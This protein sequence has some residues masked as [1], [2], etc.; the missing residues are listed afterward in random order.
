MREYK[1][2]FNVKRDA[3]FTKKQCEFCGGTENC[4][5]GV[6]FGDNSTESICLSC[7]DNKKASVDVPVYVRERIIKN[8][9]SKSDILKYT[10][11]VPWV[12]YNDWQVCCD[13]YM[14]YM[15][16]WQQ[17]D[18]INN[19]VDGDG[20]NMLEKILDKDTR[21]KVDDIKTLWDDLGYDT[22]AYIFKC[23]ACGRITAVCQSY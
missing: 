15:G 17:R 4:L 14:Q 9:I 3:A 20:I 5:E 22:V 21:E 6:Y 11:P 18:F 16:E 1:Y 7:L 12:Q 2:F 19:S 13:D 10:P 23:R 8:Q